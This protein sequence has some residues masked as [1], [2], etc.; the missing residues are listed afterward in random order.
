MADRAARRVRPTP[1]AH[2]P[3]G[4]RVKDP[5]AYPQAY[6]KGSR[7]LALVCFPQKEPHERRM[8]CSGCRASA[9]LPGQIHLWPLGGI[10]FFLMSVCHPRHF[11]GFLFFVMLIDTLPAWMRREK[12]RRDN[13][14]HLLLGLRQ[15]IF[16]DAP[17]NFGRH[18]V[19][20][21]LATLCIC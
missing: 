11:V 16:T 18:T 15:S 9:C 17:S 5:I 1:R 21:V 8:R 4:G 2:L 14:H 3:A 10:V 6:L 13:H 7:S 19:G 12:E 20:I